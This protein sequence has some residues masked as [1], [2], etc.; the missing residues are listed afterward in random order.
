[1]ADNML[2]KALDTAR[3]V[4]DVELELASK[5]Q[6]TFADAL[7][8]KLENEATLERLDG[9]VAG[10]TN[11]VSLVEGLDDGY[12]DV[13]RLRDLSVA[14]AAHDEGMDWRSKVAHAESIVAKAKEE[15]AKAERK[16]ALLEPTEERLK[17]ALS[18]LHVA[19]N[20]LRMQQ[21]GK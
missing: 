3:A 17:R 7:E 18:E 13:E 9:D 16:L 21:W 1:M 10:T 2:H 8:E 14:H 15:I 12:E 4:R 20:T 19:Q 6:Q 5:A 11:Q